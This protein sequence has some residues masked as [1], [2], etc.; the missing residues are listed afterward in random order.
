M[1][2]GVPVVAR[3]SVAKAARGA[4]AAVKETVVAVHV[5]AA[6]VIALAVARV[7]VVTVIVPAVVWRVPVAKVTVLAVP[8]IAAVKRVVRLTV[9]VR[10]RRAGRLFKGSAPTRGSVLPKAS[11]KDAVAPVAAVVL[12]AREGAPETSAAAMPQAARRDR[13]PEVIEAPAATTFLPVDATGG[14]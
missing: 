7:P 12:A 3:E 10:A 1:A 2:A 6:K 14:A 4:L 11:I 13:A 8:H 5:A 9:I